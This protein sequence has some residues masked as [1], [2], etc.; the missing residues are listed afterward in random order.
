[1][2]KIIWT[3]LCSILF[4]MFANAQHQYVEVS[5]D[6]LE[7]KRQIKVQLP[8]S[9]EKDSKKEYP[10]ILVLDADYLFEPIGGMVDYLSYW[11]EIPESIV[12]GVMQKGSRNSDL[13]VGGEN[14]LPF[15]N[16]LAFFD[17]V[18]LELTTFIEKN[19]RT[20]PLRII[21][22]HGKSANFTNFFLLKEDPLFQ[23]Y[24]NFSSFYSPEMQPRIVN[25]LKKVEK[26]TWYYHGFSENEPARPLKEMEQ[27]A[28]EGDSIANPGLF[29]LA[30]KHKD[31][32]HFTSVSQG[33]ANS[34]EHIFAV[35]KPIT[36]SE[37]QQNII[38]LESPVEYLED[39]YFDIANFYNYKIDMRINDLMFVSRAIE[40]KEIWDEY[41]QLSKLAKEHQP[42]TLLS[43]YFLAR[44]YQETGKPKKAMEYY[45]YAYDYEEVGQLTK[46]LMLMRANEIKEVFGY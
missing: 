24:I 25:A 27:L 40:E 8:R 35:F 28:A 44:Y 18:E 29:F 34:L 20:T 13:E 42:E 31:A 5:S 10:L 17:F 9:Y 21:A 45:Q 43:S 41:K 2:Y 11:E 22:G 6:F 37:Y 36:L 19:Y 14:Y 26:A 12:V 15:K 16:G 23:A 32:T 39:K 30:D 7:E 3:S 38:S 1:M 4:G 33:V 46:E